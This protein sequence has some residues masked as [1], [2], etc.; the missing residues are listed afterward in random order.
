MQL[1]VAVLYV[2]AVLAAVFAATALLLR[3]RMAAHNRAYRTLAERRGWFADLSSFRHPVARFRHRGLH[4]RLTGRHGAPYY[5]G[6]TYLSLQAPEGFDVHL[7]AE[8]RSPLAP[9]FALRGLAQGGRDF[10]KAFSVRGDPPGVCERLLG[11]DVQGR[12]LALRAR[13]P[14]TRVRLTLHPRSLS[15]HV[16]DVLLTAESLERF[17]DDALLLLDRLVESWRSAGAV[18]FLEQAE[19]KAADEAACP[20]CG[21]ALQ[22]PVVWC[23]SC[24]TPHHRECWQW[25]QG[26]ATFACGEKRFR[27]KPPP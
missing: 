6:R 4:G 23:R 19:A 27:R 9:L 3:A 14:G 20:I 17:A 7:Q 2:V 13:M 26:C 22:D 18:S 10:R 25:N 16:F 15:V 5:P 8:N 11:P 12:L 1:D 21:A 24:G